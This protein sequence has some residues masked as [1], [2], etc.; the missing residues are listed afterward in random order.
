MQFNPDCVRDVMFTAEEFTGLASGEF[1]FPRELSRAKHL[2]A[3]CEDEIR[4]HIIQCR[5]AGLI[6]SVTN[7]AGGICI[8]DVTSKGHEFLAGTRD[9]KKWKTLLRKA[10]G[11]IA[12]LVELAA[13][14]GPLLG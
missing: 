4:Y 9:N 13:A 10:P 7:V 3:Y 11:S 12:R 1:V 8:R 2:S 14:I 6:K 5:E